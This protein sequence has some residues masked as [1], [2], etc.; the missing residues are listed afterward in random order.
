MQLQHF[1][2][3]KSLG[4][5]FPLSGWCLAVHDCCSRAGSARLFGRLLCHYLVGSVAK[6]VCGHAAFGPLAAISGCAR[7]LWVC[8]GMAAACLGRYRAAV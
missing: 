2:K 7:Q 6:C 5:F 8:A 4:I 1:I 3:F